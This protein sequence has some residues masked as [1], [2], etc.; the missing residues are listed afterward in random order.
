[1]KMPEN[2]IREISH[3]FSEM[4]HMK[5]PLIVFIAIK[6][7]P[8]WKSCRR[9][10]KS[11]TR[12]DET[13]GIVLFKSPVAA[14]HPA[15]FDTFLFPSPTPLPP[16]K[17]SENNLF[18]IWIRGVSHDPRAIFIRECRV[19]IHTRLL[20]LLVSRE[21][22]PPVRD[23]CLSE[24]F[25]STFNAICQRDVCHRRSRRDAKYGIIGRPGNPLT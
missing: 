25:T 15:F 14:A 20:D 16:V 12:R 7:Y 4:E 17:K 5:I 23:A 1:M 21:P 3:S 22:S 24:Q 8:R 11:G 19:S 6:W 10:S 2:G 18:Q 13:T 9:H